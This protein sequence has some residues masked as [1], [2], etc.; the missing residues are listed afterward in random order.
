M[1]FLAVRVT[2]LHFTRPT[3][4][5]RLQDFWLQTP[6]QTDGKTCCPPIRPPEEV[7]AALTPRCRHRHYGPTRRRLHLTSPLAPQ[8]PLEPR[9][10][11]AASL[12]HL[13]GGET[14]QRRQKDGVTL[15]VA[16][17]PSILE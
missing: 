2:G 4:I 6:Y 16:R 5:C 10:V 17:R 7:Y 12:E 14:K 3:C 11:T 8:V 1:R 9:R 15:V 13:E